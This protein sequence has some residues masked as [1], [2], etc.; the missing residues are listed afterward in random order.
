MYGFII[1]VTGNVLFED[2]I[3]IVQDIVCGGSAHDNP[4]FKC[5]YVYDPDVR[6]VEILFLIKN[7]GQFHMLHI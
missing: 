2:G 1:E 3:Q 7:I 4:I 5:D 6:L